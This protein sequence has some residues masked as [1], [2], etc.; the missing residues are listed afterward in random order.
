MPSFRRIV[1]ASSSG[2]IILHKIHRK[3][4]RNLPKDRTKHPRRLKA[5]T[6][7]LG[8][9][10]IHVIFSSP[11]RQHRPWAQPILLS[12]QNLGVFGGGGGGRIIRDVK[13][14]THFLLQQRLIFGGAV[15]LVSPHAFTGCSKT[16]F[17]FFFKHQRI[18]TRNDVHSMESVRQTKEQCTLKN[19]F[20]N[21]EL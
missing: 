8:E 13:L 10:K 18:E 4:A 16:K 19:N 5:S 9:P 2:S 17:S 6:K 1:A 11:K 21:N 15:N 12:S 14:T 3:V 20:L 7:P